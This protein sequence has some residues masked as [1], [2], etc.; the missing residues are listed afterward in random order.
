M[1]NNTWIALGASAAGLI[2]GIVYVMHWRPASLPQ[3][4]TAVTAHQVVELLKNPTAVSAIESES[5]LPRSANRPNYSTGF[6]NDSPDTKTTNHSMPV[7]FLD[8][9]NLSLVRS[10]KLSNEDSDRLVEILRGEERRIR[11]WRSENKRS[12]LSPEEINDLRTESNRLARELLPDDKFQK[13]DDYRKHPAERK[14]IDR[15]NEQLT[16]SNSEA[17]SQEQEDRLH[18]VMKEEVSRTPAPSL[19]KYST[20]VEF[21]AALKQWRN[22]TMK[23]IQDRAASS[24][25]FDQLALFQLQ[26][27]A[28]VPTRNGS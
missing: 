10:L 17:L 19:S 15:L 22:D 1:R 12:F 2:V 26:S 9:E 25:T 23:R 27:T 16:R 20:H 21:E 18:A 13:Y 8:A 4:G 14:Q 6:A 28:Q 5:P 24:L 11:D 3:P 7:T